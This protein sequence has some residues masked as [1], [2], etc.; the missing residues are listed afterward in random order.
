LRDDGAKPPFASRDNHLAFCAA[1]PN[2]TCFKIP[3][4]Y[5]NFYFRFN[6]H[7]G[8]YD[9]YCFAYD[10]RYL[11]PERA[12]QHALPNYCFSVLPSSGEMI[13]IQQGESGY[14]VCNSAE[15]SPDK[16]RF[17]VDDENGLRHITRA[18]EEAMLAGS[19][20]GWDTPAAKPWNYDKNG[21]TRPLH[22]PKKDDRKR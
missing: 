19:M 9:I 20:F 10:N 16:V 8:T 1:H 12:G 11:L 3:T 13:R 15:M 4:L 18:Q 21:K 2:M 14:H 22:P 6:P 5:Y 7:Q 17:K